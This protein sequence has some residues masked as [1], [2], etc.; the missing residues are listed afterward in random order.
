MRILFYLPAVTPNWFTDNLAPLIRAAT[1]A[2]EVHVIVTPLWNGT[3]ISDAE[4]ATCPDLL[5]TVR[6]HVL[7]GPDHPSLRTNP[8]DADAVIA[9]ARAIDADYTFCRSADVTTPASFPGKVAYLMEAEFAPSLPAS[10]PVSGRVMLHGRRLYDFGFVPA[11]D[12]SLRRWLGEAIEPAW[13]AIAELGAPQVDRAAYLA[14]VDLPPDRPVIAVAL[15]CQT[16]DNVFGQVHSSEGP[17][18]AFIARI[19]ENLPGDWLL[20][21]SPHPIDRRLGTSGAIDRIAA[22]DPARIR[23]VGQRDES[24]RGEATER[25]IQHCDGLIVAESKSISLGAYYGKPIL[26]LSGFATAEWVHAYDDIAAFGAALQTGSAAVP[27]PEAMRLW[28]AYH[29]ANDAFVAAETDI[30][31]LLDRVE[32]PVNPDRWEQ[33]LMLH[34]TGA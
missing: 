9:L 11:L 5:D 32:Q 2:A 21:V 29:F 7:D 12:P 3:G 27:A 20:A 17:A 34:N 1:A 8:D 23:L 22:M 25:L 28:Y 26:R 10:V 30:A 18:D 6:W 15:Q 4:L 13:Q 19:A 31:D 16:S 33:A 14:S 24:Y